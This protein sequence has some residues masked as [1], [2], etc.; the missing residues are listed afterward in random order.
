MK[1]K[2]VSCGCKTPYEKSD[3]LDFRLGYIEGAGQLC[4]DCYE[5]V[6]MVK[7]EKNWL[8]KKHE[9]KIFGKVPS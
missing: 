4:L 6:Y 5:N 3:H 8:Q 1:D 9:D 7:R 2:C